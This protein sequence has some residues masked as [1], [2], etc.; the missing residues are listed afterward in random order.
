MSLQLK[1][2][3]AHITFRQSPGQQA[4]APMLSFRE[5]GSPDSGTPI[6]MEMV[7]LG[8]KGQV[9]TPKAVLRRL[10]IEGQ[11]PMIVET[12]SDGAIVLR[13]AGVYPIEIYGEERLRE[14]ED[15]DRMDARTKARV[16][17]ALK[18]A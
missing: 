9:S 17:K 8:R 13:H 15:A 14:F 3:E 4:I 2:D 6:C 12:T 7:T 10:G 1:L 5:S 11:V 16:A 18:K